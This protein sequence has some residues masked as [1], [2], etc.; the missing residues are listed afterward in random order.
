[1]S[2]YFFEQMQEWFLEMVMKREQKM[3]RLMAS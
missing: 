1:M 2:H 3:A